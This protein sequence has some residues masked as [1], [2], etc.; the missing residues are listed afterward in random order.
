MLMVM[1]MVMCG[2]EV[3]NRGWGVGDGV[4]ARVVASVV[5]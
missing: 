1:V 3:G 2:G 5:L 4:V